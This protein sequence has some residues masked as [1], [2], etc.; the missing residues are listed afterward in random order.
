[1]AEVV[2]L[3]RLAPLMRHPGV[4]AC[5]SADGRLYVRAFGRGGG[6]SAVLPGT[7][8]YAASLA[9]QVIGIL[10]AQQCAHGALAPGLLVRDLLPEWPSW[11]HG[12]TV[13]HLLHH[14]S[15]LPPLEPRPDVWS[16]TEVLTALKG[17]PGAVARPGVSFAYSNIGFICLAEILTQVCHR[18]VSVLASDLFADLGM[19][20]STLAPSDR[21]TPDHIAP[22]RTLGDG[23]FWTSAVDLLRWNDAMNSRALGEIVHQH[24][25]TCGHLDDGTQLDYAWGVRVLGT[26]RRRVVS[27]GGSWPTWTAK[28]VRR[29]DVGSSVALLSASDETDAATDLC[30]TLLDRLG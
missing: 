26:D 23:G 7:R 4:V 18:P 8:M 28:C 27:H 12:V 25:E 14:T 24:A 1:M 30:L 11:A 13:A 6:T 21:V 9:K 3:P 17:A 16:N 10:I 20:S 15:G 5:R 19:S 29:P 2:E 22:P